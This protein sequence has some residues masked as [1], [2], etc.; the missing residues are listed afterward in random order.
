MPPREVRSSW[1]EQAV[2]S[3]LSFDRKYAEPR[4][5]SQKKL[6][7]LQ[8]MPGNRK[9]DFNTM[10]LH[11]RFTRLMFTVGQLITLNVKLYYRIFSIK[12]PRR[13]F[14]T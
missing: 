3:L 11:F 14:K 8:V 10:L 6:P 2:L 12:R 4:Q 7:R 13:L 5:C 1:S 9:G